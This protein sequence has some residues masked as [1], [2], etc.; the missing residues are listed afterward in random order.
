M[1]GII[2]GIVVVFVAILGALLSVMVKKARKTEH[3]DEK[4]KGIRG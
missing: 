3:H 2:I 1:R 4:N